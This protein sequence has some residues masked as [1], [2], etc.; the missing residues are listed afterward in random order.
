MKRWLAIFGLLMAMPALGHEVRPAFL[1][2]TERAPG[3]FDVLWKVPAMGGAPLAGGELPHAE[4]SPAGDVNAPATMPCGCPAPTAAQLSRGVLPIHPSLPKDAVMLSLPRVER[5]FGAEIKRWTISTGTRGLD[6]WEVTVHG[7]QATMTD[8]LV[9]IALADGRVVSRMLRPDAPSFVFEKEI[10]GPAAGGYFVL[11]V[12]HILLGID[13]L[14]FVLALVLIVRGV[15]LLVKTITAFTIAHSITLALA[16][17]GFVKVPAA[18]VEAVIALSIVFVAAEIVRARRGESGLTER[19]PWL[20]AFTF[21]LLHGFGFAGALAQVGLPSH[22]IPLALLFFNVGVEAGQLGFVGVSL[23][24]LALV[25]RANF[26]FP[27]W[28]Q[29]V[30]PY[31]IGSVAMFWVI[32]RI[33]A[34]W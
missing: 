33:A 24:S 5:L 19:A 11:G 6:G 1:E 22:D 15:G 3:E 16:T 13:H 9:R 29:I 12:E 10:A 26:T 8:V 31:A 23:A 2:L 27:R 17:L 28:T 14:L 25:Q 30:P 32:Q 20:V 4:P 21:G 18:P 7:L 34:V